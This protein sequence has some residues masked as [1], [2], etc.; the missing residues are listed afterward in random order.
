MFGLTHIKY[1]PYHGKTDLVSVAPIPTT[2][3]DLIVVEGKFLRDASQLAIYYDFTKGSL[4]QAVLRIYFSHNEGTSWNQVPG[5][6]EDLT[7]LASFK[8]VYAFPIFPADKMKITVQGTGTNTGSEMKIRVM[9]K[10][11]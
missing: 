4:D 2:E 9:S 11:N 5:I 6:D 8:G 3:T 10:T 1:Q 7:F